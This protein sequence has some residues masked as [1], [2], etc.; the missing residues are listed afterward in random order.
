M[1]YGCIFIKSCDKFLMTINKKNYLKLLKSPIFVPPGIFHSS[2]HPILLIYQQMEGIHNFCQYFLP[3]IIFL[4]LIDGGKEA[5]PWRQM[6]A[7]L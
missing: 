2:K 3:I 4:I 1:Y 6:P 5:P 7:G